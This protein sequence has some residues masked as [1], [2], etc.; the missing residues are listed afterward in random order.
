MFLP[1]SAGISGHLASSMT[2]TA[3][4]VSSRAIPSITSSVVQSVVVA[5]IPATGF[6]SSSKSTTILPTTATVSSHCD[7]SS[8]YLPR[9]VQT[10]SSPTTSINPGNQPAAS[11][12]ITDAAT[13]LIYSEYGY[14]SLPEWLDSL[15]IPRNVESLQQVKEL[16]EISAMN[17]VSGQLCYAQSSFTKNWKK[18]FFV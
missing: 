16:W 9:N 3:S 12:T 2:P 15:Q 11:L 7:T 1:S 8:M 18:L 13:I 5:S 14:G 6:I 10:L 4:F 17:F